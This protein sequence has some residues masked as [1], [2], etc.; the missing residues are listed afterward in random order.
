MI[1]F[2]LGTHVRLGAEALTV[3]DQFADRRVLVVTDPGVA[4]TGHSDRVAEQIRGFGMEAVV[5][6]LA[7][8][9]PIDKGHT[10]ER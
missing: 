4:A 7:H 2:R 3:L 9:E 6:D 1:E 8:V 5:T 10:D